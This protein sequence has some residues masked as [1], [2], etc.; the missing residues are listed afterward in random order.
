VNLCVVPVPPV[1]RS[2]IQEIRR[3]TDRAGQVVML[4]HNKPFLCRIWEG[5]DFTIRSAIQL[6]RDG[7]GST[8]RSWDVEQDCVT[9]HDRRHALLRDYLLTGSPNNREV[10]IALRPSL[11]AFLRV[12]CPGSFPAGSLIGP[13][14]NICVQR[15]GTARQILDAQRIQ[16]LND[17]LEY[18]NKFH[19]DTNTACETE[20]INDGELQ[21]FV[22]RTLSFTSP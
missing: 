14:L 17:L 18:A 2:P 22:R 8:I 12:A 9:E 16:E 6:A 20:Q 1:S 15:V 13:F 10:A 19:H 5:T 11:E 4:S 21:G 7:T 3:L